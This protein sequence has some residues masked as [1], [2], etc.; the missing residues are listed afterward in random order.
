MERDNDG[1][2]QKAEGGK[3]KYKVGRGFAALPPH[4]AESLWLSADA[5]YITEAVPPSAE[6]K[7]R[8]FRIAVGKAKPFRTVRGGRAAFEI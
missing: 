4:S 3:Q 8:I 6:A 5:D 2:R 7:P 1:R